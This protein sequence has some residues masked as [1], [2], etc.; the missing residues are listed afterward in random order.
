MFPSVKKDLQ[1]LEP[2]LIEFLKTP[3]EPTNQIISHIFQSGGKRIRPGLFLLVCKLV[4]Y[5]GEHVYPIASVCEYIHT[6]SLLH[7]DV[8]DNS[9]L[10][11]NK[12]TANSIWGDETAVLAGDLIYSASCRLMVKSRSLELIDT[13]AECI[14]FMSESELFQLELLW[15]NNIKEKD[16]FRVVHGKTAI[17]FE[18]CTKTPGYLKKLPFEHVELLGKI[19]FHLGM[20]FQI[21]DDC[22]DFDGDQ[23]LVGKAL[24]A[25]LKEGKC[26][27]PLLIA[28]QKSI[29]VKKS[30]ESVFSGEEKND[31]FFKLISLQVVSCGA[32]I[33]A[34]EVAQNHV[35]LALEALE[36]WTGL[37]LK[38]NNMSA[39]SLE[40]KSA[41]D[42]LH[43][44][45]KLILER[46]N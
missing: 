18:A 14:R 31:E 9:T 2:L 41:F 39:L 11:R 36:S 21:S 1:T 32:L 4:N 27:L 34:K 30:V 20:A 6:A 25:D 23:T 26:T 8:I 16:Y 28:Q 29:E 7:D 46:K 43:M 12:P 22:L 19:G 33:E 13:F 3:N 24:S 37:H 42:D 44:L 35:S 40:Q 5:N 17:L 38:L 45:A 10:R 15:N